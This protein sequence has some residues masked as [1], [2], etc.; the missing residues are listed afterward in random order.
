MTNWIPSTS[1]S[2]D[3]FVI[4]EETKQKLRGIQPYWHG[5]THQDEVYAGMSAVN[6]QAQKQNVI[7]RGGISMSGDGHIIPHHEKILAKGYR[8]IQRDAQEA[9]K[10]PGLSSGPDRFLQR[11]GDRH[12][13]GHQICAAFFQTGI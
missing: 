4:S 13:S 12:G 1:R 3:F 2:G 5:K 11:G 6:M 10:K 8:G 7:H 9:L